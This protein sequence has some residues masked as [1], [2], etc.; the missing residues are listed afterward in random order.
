MTLAPIRSR[1]L[2]PSLLLLL[3]AVLSQTSI[4]KTVPIIGSYTNTLGAQ[5]IRLEP[6]EN[7]QRCQMKCM[8]AAVVEPFCAR[9]GGVFISVCAANCF[10]EDGAKVYGCPMHYPLEL[11]DYHCRLDVANRCRA[12]AATPKAKTVVCANNGQVYDN[13]EQA[14]C[15]VGEQGAS[16]FSCYKY[17]QLCRWRCKN[18]FARD[19][20]NCAA[21]TTVSSQQLVCGSDGN[22][23]FGA[24]QAAC[25]G[26]A[27]NPRMTCSVSA[28]RSSCQ[29]VC[30][31]RL[32]VV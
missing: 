21:L 31:G 19:K 26:V 27:I 6:D 8:G 14:R 30:M 25:I 5:Q 29:G 2:A 1:Q 24:G 10:G 9:N 15:D 32:A 12:A 3:S 20:G 28:V 13:I 17:D 4:P 7:P 22:W 16:V 18:A 11:C 23:Y